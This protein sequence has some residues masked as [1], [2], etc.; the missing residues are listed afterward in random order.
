MKLTAFLL[1][2]SARAAFAAT[3]EQINTNFNVA[4]GGTL[5]VNVDF[6]SI[7]VGTN[8]AAQSGLNAIE[9]LDMCA[10]QLPVD[11]PPPQSRE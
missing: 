1:L 9:V 8:G 6:G 5:V 10:D 2:V 11:L 7:T 4:P 3:E